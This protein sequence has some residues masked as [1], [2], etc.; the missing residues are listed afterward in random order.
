VNG[1]NVIK[2]ASLGAVLGVALSLTAHSARAV[3]PAAG[4]IG[5]AIALAMGLLYRRFTAAPLAPALGGSALTGLLSGFAGIVVAFALGDQP[6]AVLAG[7]T[8]GSAAAGAIGGLLGGIG[9]KSPR[10]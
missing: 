4:P 7:G 6:V 5:A 8:V 3:L 9:L 2:F 1:R 10:A